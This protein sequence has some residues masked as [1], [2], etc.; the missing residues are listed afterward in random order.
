[1]VL[2]SKAV[3]LPKVVHLIIHPLLAMQL[4]G[5]LN[6]AF[7]FDLCLYDLARAA[8]CCHIFQLAWPSSP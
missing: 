2:T 4:M 5:I 6:T 8:N 3:Q 7:I 1:M